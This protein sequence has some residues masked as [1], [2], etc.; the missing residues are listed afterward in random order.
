[1][2]SIPIDLARALPNNVGWEGSHVV[3]IDALTRHR[4]AL[5]RCDARTG[6]CEVAA[7]LDRRSVTAL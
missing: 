7:E 5:L 4:R 3:V 1:M 2:R 6:A